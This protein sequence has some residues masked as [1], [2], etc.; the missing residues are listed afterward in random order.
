[1]LKSA[2]FLCVTLI[3]NVGQSDQVTQG[4]ALNNR[5]V[6]IGHYEQTN[7]ATRYIGQNE[8]DAMTGN[9]MMVPNTNAE[10]AAKNVFYTNDVPLN[11]ASQAQAAYQLPNTPVYRVTVMTREV[12]NIYGGNVAGGSGTELITRQQMQAVDVRRL[13]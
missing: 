4:Q 12:V 13:N 7:V 3:L 9:G 10:G 1:M 11:S 2:P 5:E 6:L 8:Y